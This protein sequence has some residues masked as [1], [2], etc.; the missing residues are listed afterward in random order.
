[1]RRGCSFGIKTIDR[2][3]ERWQLLSSLS[4]TFDIEGMEVPMLSTFYSFNISGSFSA[5]YTCSSSLTKNLSWHSGGSA[6]AVA[7]QPGPAV[8]NVSDFRHCY[9]VMILGL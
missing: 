2:I 1:M 6:R 8:R 5:L 9:H 3:L 7:H 4:S